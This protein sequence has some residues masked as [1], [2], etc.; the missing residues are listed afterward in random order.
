[1]QAAESVLY[2]EKKVNNEEINKKE[3][4]KLA[5]I[6]FPYWKT[7]FKEIKVRMTSEKEIKE[8]NKNSVVLTSGS[9]VGK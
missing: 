8:S 5:N 2:E 1:M 3:I 9:L 4:S 7:I 6:D